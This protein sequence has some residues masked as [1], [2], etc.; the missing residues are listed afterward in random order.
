MLKT[1][2]KDKT[3]KSEKISVS[4]DVKNPGKGTLTVAYVM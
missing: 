3:I 4:L 2:K 1:E